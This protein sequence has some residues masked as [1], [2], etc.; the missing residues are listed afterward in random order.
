MLHALI[1]NLPETIGRLP[2]GTEFF[3]K[4]KMKLDLRNFTIE[5]VESAAGLEEV[6]ELRR[7]S[8]VEDFVGLTQPDYV[9]FDNYDLIAD[10]IVV[11]SK[12]TG[13]IVSAYRII[14]WSLAGKI[15]SEV[16]YDLRQFVKLPGNK[17]ELGRAV[18]H[19]DHRNGLT[20]SLVWKGIAQYA[21]LSKARYLCGCASVKTLDQNVAESIFWHLSPFFYNQSRSVAVL[22]EFQKDT[23]FKPAQ[24][25]PWSEVE[26]FVPPLLKFYLKAGAEILSAPAYD[27]FFKCV[28]YFTV[29]DIEQMNGQHHERYFGSGV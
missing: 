13:T 18:V 4:I 8:F 23:F 7:H 24:L 19:K 16:Q 17:I 12:K 14:N 21:A 6:I 2:Y 15:Y 11:R 27:N 10:H 20:L 29:L 9:D 5:T 28:D 22:P 1:Q 26:G 25:L 3:A